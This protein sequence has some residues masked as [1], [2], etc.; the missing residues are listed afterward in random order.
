[1]IALQPTA[2][3]SFDL[4]LHNARGVVFAESFY[5][6]LHNYLAGMNE[7][8]SPSPFVHSHANSSAALTAVALLA[9]PT[10]K[11]PTSTGLG[12][13]A[14]PSEETNGP[15]PNDS[16]RRI[17]RVWADFNNVEPYLL[18]ELAEG[19]LQVD[20]VASGTT[21]NVFKASGIVDDCQVWL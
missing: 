9:S 1:M 17:E 13:T 15:L 4:L 6:F 20:Y 18:P 21:S 11:A 14:L 19:G 12:P 16:D 3:P 5:S 2:R 10:T 8:P 7:I